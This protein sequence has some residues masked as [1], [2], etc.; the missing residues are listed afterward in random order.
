MLSKN[1]KFI[2]WW[3]IKN[4]FKLQPDIFSFFADSFW[5]LKKGF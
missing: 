2:K 4:L 1:D 5:Q 3:I